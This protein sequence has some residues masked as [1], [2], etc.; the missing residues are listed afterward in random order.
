MKKKV[1]G[2]RT[3]FYEHEYHRTGVVYSCARD[4]QGDLHLKLTMRRISFDG[5]KDVDKF[6]DSMETFPRWLKLQAY[7]S[8][9]MLSMES[10]QEV[11]QLMKESGRDD[12][13]DD[14]R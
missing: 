14:N 3:L 6:A 7:V 10:E 4:E 12:I 13:D 11:Q 2:P 1:S 9:S 8:G 5:L